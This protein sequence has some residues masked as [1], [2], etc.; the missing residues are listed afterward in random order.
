VQGLPLQSGSVVVVVVVEVS[1]VV[2]VLGHAGKQ[3]PVGAVRLTQTKPS[4]QS[5]ED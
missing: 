2:V 4:P 5:V 1:V 3:V